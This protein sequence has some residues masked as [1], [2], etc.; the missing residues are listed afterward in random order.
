MFYCAAQV[1]QFLLSVRMTLNMMNPV[2][3]FSKTTVLTQFQKMAC[4]DRYGTRNYLHIFIFINTSMVEISAVY[5]QMVWYMVWYLKM[6]HE[7]AAVIRSVD[8]S[9]TSIAV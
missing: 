2:R 5:K 9:P 4:S 8:Q 6:F 7:G 3:V 1:L